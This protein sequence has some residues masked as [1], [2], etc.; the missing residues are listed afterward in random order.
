MNG[1]EKIVRAKISVDLPV[2]S[3]SEKKSGRHYLTTIIVSGLLSVFLLLIISHTLSETTYSVSS[4]LEYSVSAALILFLSILLLRY[5]IILLM[6]YLNLNKYTFEN[7]N[8]FHP[9]VS[10]VIPAYNEE[11][12][13]KYTVNSMLELNYPNYEIIIVNDGSTDNTR[14]IAEAFAGYRKGKYKDIK[15]TLINKENSGKAAALN[16][17]IKYSEAEFILCMDSDSQASPDSLKRG[18]RHLINSSVGA[19]AGNVKVLNR[20]MFLTDLQALEYMEG[21]NLARSAQSYIKLVNIV[22]G[23]FGIFRKTA[24]EQAGYYSGETFAEDADLTL[25]LI[26]GGWKVSYEPESVSYTEA[27]EKI[28]QLLKQRYRWSR[29]IIQSIKKNRRM[30][31]TF[32]MRKAF[33][34]STM[35]Y[36]A[37]IW[38]VMNVAAH[39][40]FIAAAFSFGFIS[41]I[42]FWWAALTLLDL[43]AAVYC[44]AS[45]KEEIRLVFYSFIYRVFFTLI[46]DVC[47]IFSAIDEFFGIKMTW[48]KLERTGYA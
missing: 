24:L 16:A 21:L 4:L 15:I 48:G 29:G 34:F 38:P 18:I 41:L 35:F 23:P 8:D 28:N 46:V 1:A 6:A 2:Y 27:P 37:M 9:F 42:F 26:S 11:K 47:R 10:I 5:L 44:I 14:E 43:I 39:F 19:V 13:L 40:I 12:L 7:E 22:P 45:E 32:S 30:N 3:E 31:D 17:G 20:G 33:V 25:K 36:E